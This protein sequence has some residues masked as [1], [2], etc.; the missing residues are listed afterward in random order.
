[1]IIHNLTNK[2]VYSANEFLT[3]SNLMKSYDYQWSCCGRHVLWIGL[4]TVDQYYGFII[5]AKAEEICSSAFCFYP[6]YF[7]ILNSYLLTICLIYRYINA[8]IHYKFSTPFGWV[9]I[10]TIITSFH[11]I[12]VTNRVY[13]ISCERKRFEWRLDIE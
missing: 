1:M 8:F 9:L 2:G 4:D 12:C 10:F 13:N 7:G 5:I 3:R 11:N 6:C